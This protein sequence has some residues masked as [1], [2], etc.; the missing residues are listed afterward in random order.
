MAKDLW[1]RAGVTF[2]LTDE[3]AHKLLIDCQN[4]MQERYEII[5]KVIDDGRFEFDGDCYSPSEV[6]E[7]YNRKYGTNLP[8]EDYEHYW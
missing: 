2:H 5:K 6:I 3:E 1:A 4:N 7:E 8:E